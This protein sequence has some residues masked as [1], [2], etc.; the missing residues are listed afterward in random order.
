MCDSRAILFCFL[1]H[2]L[3]LLRWSSRHQLSAQL[4]AYTI[5]LTLSIFKPPIQFLM[6]RIASD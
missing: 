4:P 3:F 2:L 1:Q 5:K 6:T